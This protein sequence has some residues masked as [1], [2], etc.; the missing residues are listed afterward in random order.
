MM[1]YSISFQNML[2]NIDFFSFRVTQRQTMMR[3]NDDLFIGLFI[4]NTRFML[5]FYMNKPF[6]KTLHDKCHG[7]HIK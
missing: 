4:L 7:M 1:F 3:K 5:M 2:T 6:H